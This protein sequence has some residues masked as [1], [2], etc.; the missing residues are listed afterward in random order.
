MSVRIGKN[1]IIRGRDSE[2]GEKDPGSLSQRLRAS[3]SLSE[4]LVFGNHQHD[5]RR[6]A[7]CL[8][9]VLP[10]IPGDIHDAQVIPRL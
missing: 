6:E 3:R 4:S 9:G 1:M 8:H 10:S 5:R 2:A 7:S